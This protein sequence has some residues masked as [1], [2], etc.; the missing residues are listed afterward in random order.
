VITNPIENFQAQ[1][2]ADMEQFGELMHRHNRADATAKVLRDQLEG[3]VEV[4]LAILEGLKRYE[5]NLIVLG[6]DILDEDLEV[7]ED[8]EE[9]EEW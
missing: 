9:D 1:L 2:L 4:K 8:I 3:A 7:L 5:E 6:D